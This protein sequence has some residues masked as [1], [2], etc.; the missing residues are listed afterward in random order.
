MSKIIALDAGHGKYTAGKRITLNGYEPTPEWWLNDRI[1]DMVQ[2][3][4]EE[5]YDCTVLRVDDTTGQKD[6]SLANRVKTANNA[7]ADVYLS[8]HHNAGINGG[9]GGGTVVFYYSSDSKRKEQ[10]QKLYNYITDETKL[11]G[12]RSERVIKKGFYVIKKTKAPAFLV[13]NGFMDSTTDVPIILSE[14]HAKKTAQGVLA[15]LVDGLSLVKK[16]AEN[17]A[18][19]EPQMVYQ[20]YTVKKGDTLI[21]IGNACCVDYMDIIKLN[22]IASPYTIYPGQVL[23][24]ALVNKSD[25]YYPAYTG[26]KTTLSAAMTTLGIDNSYSFR[27]QIAKANNITLYVGTAQQNTQMYNLLCAGLLKRE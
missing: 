18:N 2:A 17:K 7:N 4:L 9:S 8:M 5:N 10:A 20:T 26:P 14:E 19:T 15:F 16:K 23:K 22:N 1:M 24:V 11:Y 12:N 27:K 6:I 13:E 21:K 25:I 3:E